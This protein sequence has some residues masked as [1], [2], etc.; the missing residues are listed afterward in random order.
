MTRARRGPRDRQDHLRERSE[1]VAHHRLDEQR[2]CDRRLREH[3]AREDRGEDAS[4]QRDGRRHRRA[5]SSR[6]RGRPRGARRRT[7]RAARA[8]ARARASRRS[9][10]RSRQRSRAGERR[11]LRRVERAVADERRPGGEHEQGEDERQQEPELTGSEV[12]RVLASP[13][14]PV[15]RGGSPR[16]CAACT[17][18]RAR[19][20]G[21]RRP[22]SPSPGRRRRP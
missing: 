10:C 21:P 14:S 8:S 17:S 6:A 19:F 18:R 7:H 22:C 5:A 16:S 9:V 15:A 2:L 4:E 13:R 1:A 20:R 3:D 11:V 12:E